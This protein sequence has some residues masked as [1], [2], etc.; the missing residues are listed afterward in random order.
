MLMRA[1][2]VIEWTLTGHA[3]TPNVGDAGRSHFSER[4]K[5]MKQCRLEEAVAAF[6]AALEIFERDPIF[7]R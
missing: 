5:T 7:N 4:R 6:N 2:L 3:Q 1:K